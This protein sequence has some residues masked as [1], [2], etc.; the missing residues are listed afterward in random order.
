MKSP[1]LF[2][3][4]IGPEHER[5]IRVASQLTSLYD[6]WHTTEPGKGSDAKSGKWQIKW[7]EDEEDGKK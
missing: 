1:A 2:A 4:H 6:A 3:D 7:P 5:A